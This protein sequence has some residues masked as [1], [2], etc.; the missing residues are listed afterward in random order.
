[1]ERDIPRGGRKQRKLSVG[2]FHWVFAL[3]TLSIF[4]SIVQADEFFGLKTKNKCELKL[5]AITR[6]HAGKVSLLGFKGELET[7]PVDQVQSVFVFNSVESPFT[8]LHYTQ[9][10]IVEMKAVYIDQL[11][12][13]NFY[14]WPVRFI[15]NLVVFTDTAGKNHVHDLEKILKMRT[16]TLADVEAAAEKSQGKT[17]TFDLRDLMPDCPGALPAKSG[18]EELRPTRTLTD[19]IRIRQL[20]DDLERGYDDLENLQ[21]RTLFYA[22][23]FLF[24]RKGRLGFIFTDKKLEVARDVPVYFSFTNGR[25]FRFQSHTV[26]GAH[27]HDMLPKLEPML[28][29]RSDIKAHAFHAHVSGNIEAFEGGSKYFVNQDKFGTAGQENGLRET[30]VQNAFN[31]IAMMGFDYGPFSISAGSY[32]PIYAIRVQREIREIR[33]NESA[34]I[35]GLGYTNQK[36]KVNLVLAPQK[37]RSVQQPT[38]RDLLSKD[39]IS[40]F[41][42]DIALPRDLSFDYGFWRLG[43]EYQILERL[44]AGA[45]LFSTT[46]NY[47]EVATTSTNFMHYQRR[48]FS[49]FARQEFGDYI[50]LGVF[51][52]FSRSSYDLS[53]STSQVKKSF[54][55]FQLGGSLE[56]IF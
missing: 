34:S 36:L 4:P 27:V 42:V 9:A 45:S 33:A 35:F 31:Y 18:Q 56:F 3:V 14:G 5:G 41:A 46:L 20:F 15:D 50:S 29:A 25:P 30:E 23:P 28:I 48:A 12:R 19:E 10:S 17:F 39:K 11:D 38:D 47:R 53:F 13:P 52:N 6:V 44:S 55:Y 40:G 26:L 16:P 22:R 1:M 43:G 32:Y 54:Q 24:Q 21:E 7:I 37:K 2:D 49:I 51:G 8:D